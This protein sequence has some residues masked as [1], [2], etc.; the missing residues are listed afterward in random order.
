MMKNI[1][2]RFYFK[3]TRNGNLLG[4]FSNNAGDR[5]WTE[6]CDL[7][8]GDNCD[9]IGTYN[10]SWQE[11]GKALFANLSI[12]RK[13]GENS[14]IFELTWQRNGKLIFQGEGMLCDDMLVGDYNYTQT[15]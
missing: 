5:S 2:G 12:S 15:A 6:S 7:I 4:E 13:G 9:F 1:R 10:S 11:N 8:D 3:K 14:Q